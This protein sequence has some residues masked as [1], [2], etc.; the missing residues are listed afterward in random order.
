MINHDLLTAE[1]PDSVLLGLVMAKDNFQEAFEIF[2]ERFFKPKYDWDLIGG[3]CFIFVCDH[4]ALKISLNT[5]EFE[6]EVRALCYPEKT[7]SCYLPTTWYGDGVN[8]KIKK[9]LISEFMPYL[10]SQIFNEDL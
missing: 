9:A 8:P 7:V 5:D 6:L 1:N 2:I 10:Y 3:D 4:P